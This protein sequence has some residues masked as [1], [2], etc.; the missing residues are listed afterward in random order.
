M[1]KAVLGV[2]C[3][4][5]VVLRANGE[6]R[7]PDRCIMDYRDN[8]PS[9]FGSTNIW[10]EIADDEAALKWEWSHGRYHFAVALRP[11]VVTSQM[12][13]ATK[14]L[15]Q[16]VVSL[17]AAEIDWVDMCIWRQNPTGAPGWNLQ[18]EPMR[19]DE[20]LCALVEAANKR[21]A[22]V[23]GS[24]PYERSHAALH[25]S[26]DGWY[27]HT[28]SDFGLSEISP[29]LNSNVQR[30]LQ[31]ERDYL[32][33]LAVIKSRQEQREEYTE[34]YERYRSIIERAGGILVDVGADGFCLIVDGVSEIYGL[35][36]G[37]FQLF[38][39][40]I[41]ELKSSGTASQET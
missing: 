36:E 3:S 13:D 9:Q 24:E 30:F 21:L 22:A 17:H 32:C 26:E 1:K 18:T 11:A 41:D 14:R 25:H 7:Q 19:T 35:N 15:Y 38:T 20:E 39:R 34:K 28:D 8:T 12:L 5:G 4:D 40:Y 10:E 29:L 37:D 2:L 31:Q 33:H 23:P 16:E 27:L 6:L